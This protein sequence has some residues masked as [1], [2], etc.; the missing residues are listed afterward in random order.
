MITVTYLW[1]VKLTCKIKCVVYFFNP[2]AKYDNGKQLFVVMFSVATLLKKKESV[3]QRLLSV[4]W[5]CHFSASKVCN[6]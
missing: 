4:A 6:I 5:A 3:G 2:I 1:K